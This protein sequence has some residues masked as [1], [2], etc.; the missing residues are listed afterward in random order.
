MLFKRV[1]DTLN[2]NFYKIGILINFNVFLKCIKNR[3]FKFE[4]NFE[5]F[6]NTLDGKVLQSFIN[7]RFGNNHLP[8]EKGRW[9]G[10]ERSERKCKMSFLNE[11]G[12]EFHYLFRCN[13]KHIH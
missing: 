12:D 13:A 4:H 9:S 7:F 1:D 5:K 3:M 6:F 11:V 8:I 10:I 2:L